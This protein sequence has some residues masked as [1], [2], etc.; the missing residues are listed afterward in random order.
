MFIQKNDCSLSQK[1]G[2]RLQIF[3]LQFLLK[4]LLINRTYNGDSLTVERRRKYR[5]RG[6]EWPIEKNQL[7]K[8]K[9]LE[10]LLMDPRRMGFERL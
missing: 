4:L 7:G 5:K 1:L 2:H 3:Y 10:S 6:R 8:S 9:I